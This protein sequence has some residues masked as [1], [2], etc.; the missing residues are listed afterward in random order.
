M[1]QTADEP[2]ETTLEEE[3]ARTRRRGIRM[4]MQVAALAIG[5]TGAALAVTAEAQAEPVAAAGSDQPA[6][7]AEP[8]KP[9]TPTGWSCWGAPVSRGPAAP[10][11]LSEADFAALYAEVPS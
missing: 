5:A 2:R 7:R 8:P 4:A 9:I 3:K 1:H 6:D 11:A 10:P